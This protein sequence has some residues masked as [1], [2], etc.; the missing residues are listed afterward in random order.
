MK[1]LHV[2]RV[3][4]LG[5]QLP[6]ARAGRLCR[7]AALFVAMIGLTPATAA[8]GGEP[9]FVAGSTTFCVIDPS[10]GFDE[11]AGMSDGLRLL[12]V[13]AWYPVAPEAVEGQEKA[14]FGDYFAND[15]DLLQRTERALLTSSGFAPETIEAH[16]LLAPEQFD[17]PRD[18][19][20]DAPVAE[21]GGPFPVVVYS[22]GTL[23]QRFTN[24]SLAESLARRGYIVLAP[25]HTGNDAL[26]PLGAYC[27]VE[28]ARGGVKP[29]GLDSQPAFDAARGEYRGQTFDPFFLVGSPSPEAG[30]I[31]PVEVALTLDRVGDYRAVL[32]A[33]RE[34]FAGQAILRPGSVGLIG[35]SRGGMHGLVG[36]ELIPEIGAS[37]S[38]VGGT[39]LLFY[40]RD[41]E[42]APIH[43][44][45]S[46]AT[47][48]KRTLLDRLT[49]P[50]LELIGGEDSR[51]KASTDVA[52]A[53]GVYPLPSEEN[54]SPIVRDTFENLG[55]TF[56]VLVQ[57]EAIDHFDLVDDPFVIAYRAQGGVSRVGA[58]DPTQTYLTRP[59]AERQRIRDH[60]VHAMFDRFLQRTVRQH[61]RPRRHGRSGSF[62]NPFV[63]AG[64]SV[65]LNPARE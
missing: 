26:A 31:N 63:N 8:A 58:F 20:R 15:P 23:Q 38:L 13:E 24:D 46:R 51:R 52:A 6:H 59:V 1:Y 11:A 30:T 43:L 34:R 65:E 36:A 62:D 19:Y 27:P 47:H 18:S 45:L 53:I 17:V 57:V 48:G 40:T 54:P 2:E 61:H 9:S 64:V 39:P 42:A 50:V 32:D 56:G 37:V 10:R 49:K 28:L 44:A 41:A 35:Y 16:M 21:R 60:F 25:E 12:I 14:R 55:K 5:L 29:E 4:E 3:R 33:A 7:A 22:H